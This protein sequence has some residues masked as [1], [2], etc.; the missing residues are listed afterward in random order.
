MP[1]LARVIETTVMLFIG[2]GIG[3]AAHAAAKRPRRSAQYPPAQ[4]TGTG[5]SE[6][7]SQKRMGDNEYAKLVREMIRHEDSVLAQRVTWCGSVEGLLLAALGFAW[8][9]A[10][11]WFVIVV[12]L[13]GLLVAAVSLY[14]SITT[15]NTMQG[16]TDQWNDRKRNDYDGPPVIGREPK[17]WNRLCR[18]S[19]GIP[20]AF[21]L[22]W[23]AIAIVRHFVPF[24][25]HKP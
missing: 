6:P 3:V 7:S 24:G 23:V 19:R 25:S 12:G 20:L 5:R 10:S 11:E 4:P 9:S 16:L 2:L 13:V 21:M 1:D 15:T 17:N 18:P 22:L 14:A 8:N